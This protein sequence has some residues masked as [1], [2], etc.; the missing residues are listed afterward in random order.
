MPY[1]ET[2]I[3]DI[4]AANE[5]ITD[6]L[7]AKTD[8]LSI[9]CRSFLDRLQEHL[10][11]ET[12]NSFYSAQIRT[13]FRLNPNTLKYYLRELVKY[14]QVKITGGNR[15]GRGYEYELINMDGREVMR[16]NIENILSQMLK[17]LVK[18]TG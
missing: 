15:Y 4:K 17:K 18:S 11:K 5:L 14:G 10:K 3:E 16:Q 7:M 13:A 2:S 9:G 6:I 12:G 8:E 1:I